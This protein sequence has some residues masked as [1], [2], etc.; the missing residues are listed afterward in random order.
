M[1]ILPSDI[2]VEKTLYQYMSSL[3]LTLYLLLVIDVNM[4]RKHTA[5]LEYTPGCSY[6]LDLESGGV[7]DL[8]TN[9]DWQHI[10]ASHPP[11][12]VEVEMEVDP[13]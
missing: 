13:Q 8:F 2:E 7:S 1:W 9:T 6:V 3:Y 11:V 10:V 4:N 12:V 5:S